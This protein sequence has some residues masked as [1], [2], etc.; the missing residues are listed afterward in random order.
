MAVSFTESDKLH[1]AVLHFNHNDEVDYN[2]DDDYSGE[3]TVVYGMQEN[4]RRGACTVGAENV[5]IA[6]CPGIF[7]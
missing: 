4:G 5:L 3:S 6:E 7:G 1:L 2:D